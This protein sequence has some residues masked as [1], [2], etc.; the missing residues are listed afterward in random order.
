MVHANGCSSPKDGKPWPT[1]DFHPI[2][3]FCM[4]KTHHIPSPFDV[5]SSI[6]QQVYKAVLDAY[7]GYHR[8]LLDKASIKLTTFIMELGQYQYLLA[9]QGHL[10]S[11]DAYTR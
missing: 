6:P 2:T 5:V 4:R 7:N 1:V 10:A 11:G 8:V 3:K 9:P